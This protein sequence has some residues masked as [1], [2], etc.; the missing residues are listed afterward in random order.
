[1][2]RFCAA[3]I[4]PLTE[5]VYAMD[6]FTDRDL[7]DLTLL[8]L[9]PSLQ[10]GRNNVIGTRA[11]GEVLDSIRSLVE[12]WITLDGEATIRF[13]APHGGVFDV[14]AG[15][16]P[17][18]RID[19]GAGLQTRRILAIEVKGGADASNAHNRAGEAEKSQIKA[20]GLGYV[21][22]WTVIV[23]RGLNRAR[24]REETPSSTEVFDANQVIQRNGADW[25]AFRVKFLAAIG[26]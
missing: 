10:G 24:I 19:S 20:K 17:D 11:A 8:T 25:E 3:L 9:G 16:D 23:M 26:E 12:P 18:I 13:E 2:D 21:Q 4:A 7:S 15:S 1:L 5:L 6:V 14:I 22:R